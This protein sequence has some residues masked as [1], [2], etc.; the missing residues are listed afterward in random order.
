MIII[1][2]RKGKKSSSHFFP[3]S[4]SFKDATILTFAAKAFKLSRN[5]CQKSL[6][7]GRSIFFRLSLV[8]ASTLTY[9]WVTGL[10]FLCNL[11]KQKTG[12]KL[13]LRQ[14][15]HDVELTACRRRGNGTSHGSTGFCLSRRTEETT[16]ILWQNG[17]SVDYVSQWLDAILKKLKAFNYLKLA[18]LETLAFNGKRTKWDLASGQAPG[19]QGN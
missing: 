4:H 17:L 14:A 8:L 16:F 6:K 15:F 7:S 12:E 18:P 13:C 9:S 2:K 5:L 11:K 3:L 1:L 10:R 19:A